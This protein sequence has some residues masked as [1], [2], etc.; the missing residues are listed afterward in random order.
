[1]N[2]DRGIS[3][4]TGDRHVPSPPRRPRTLRRYPWKALIEKDDSF[5][6]MVPRSDPAEARRIARR[7]Y[8][9]ASW[10]RSRWGRV[11]VIAISRSYEFVQ[12]WFVG[13]VGD[14]IPEP[15]PEVLV[16]PRDR[17]NER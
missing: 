12:C 8:A 13:L 3:L 4:A 5:A 6:V 7:L 11:H 10:Q 1:M 14:A 9:S 15:P 2:G 16:W 17:H